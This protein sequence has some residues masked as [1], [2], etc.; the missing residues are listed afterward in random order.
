MFKTEY[1]LYDII[2]SIGAI[3]IH[4]EVHLKEA[5]SI[6]NNGVFASAWNI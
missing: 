6:G 5:I 2:F 4:T 3:S 1:Y